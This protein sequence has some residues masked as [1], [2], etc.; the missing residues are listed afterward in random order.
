VSAN[1]AD[2]DNF[3]SVTVKNTCTSAVDAPQMTYAVIT[4]TPGNG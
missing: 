3:M 2:F 1:V 4:F